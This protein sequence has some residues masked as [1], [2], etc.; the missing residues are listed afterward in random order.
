MLRAPRPWDHRYLS[1]REI[2]A[3]AGT[4]RAVSPRRGPGTGG[5]R[6]AEDGHCPPPRLHLPTR[7]RARRAHAPR[8]G[9]RAAAQ[10][11]QRDRPPRAGAGLHP[12]R[13]RAHCLGKGPGARRRCTRGP[14][15]VRRSPAQA[16]VSDPRRLFPPLSQGDAGVPAERSRPL[17]R[18]G[19]SPSL[20][21]PA[22]PAGLSPCL[23]SL[24]LLDHA[25][26]LRLEVLVAP[27]AAG[28]PTAR[29]RPPPPAVP[30]GS[31]RAA[32]G[33]CRVVSRRLKGAPP[34]RRA[35]SSWPLAVGRPLA[36][37]VP[38][39]PSLA[40]GSPGPSASCGWF[41]GAVAETAPACR[42]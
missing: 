13:R 15:P 37:C 12:G 3:L 31:P 4:L 5:K 38:P 8:G 18:E 36:V 42:C 9:R 25:R 19:A 2:P 23:S 34:L 30:V 35:G 22:A 6:R 33:R 14:L 26:A 17:P 29:P 16:L 39:L 41:S 28:D 40:S 11:R 7:R 27:G 20:R 10:P 32:A 1:P 24:A 21:R